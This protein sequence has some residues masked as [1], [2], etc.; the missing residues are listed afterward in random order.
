MCDRVCNLRAERDALRKLVAQLVDFMCRQDACTM[1]CPAYERCVGS[2]VC[3]F[4][5]WARERARELGVEVD[6]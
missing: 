6:G 3:E 2:E 1:E 5:S 4:P